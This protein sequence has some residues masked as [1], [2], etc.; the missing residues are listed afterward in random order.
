MSLEL[1]H[2]CDDACSWPP[3]EDPSLRAQSYFVT[4]VLCDIC[5][6]LCNLL[7]DL[8]SGYIHRHHDTY[9]GTSLYIYS[10]YIFSL[11]M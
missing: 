10:V 9:G 3:N 7:R 2:M 5:D 8:P 11:W 6:I 1:S 4:S